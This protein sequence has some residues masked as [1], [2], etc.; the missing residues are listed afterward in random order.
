LVF[1]SLQEIL[2]LFLFRRSKGPASFPSPIIVQ[3]FRMGKPWQGPGPLFTGV[4]RAGMI[5]GSR[6][7]LQKYQ[8]MR[9]WTR[10][11]ETVGAY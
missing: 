5:E 4:L 6:G 11:T 10:G 8:K 3:L 9:G 2:S 1:L 7:T